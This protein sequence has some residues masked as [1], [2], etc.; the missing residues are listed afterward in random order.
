M[1][2]PVDDAGVEE[3]AEV[4]ATG[5]GGAAAGRLPAGNAGTVKVPLHNGHF[6]SCPANCSGTV[7]IF[8]HIGQSRFTR[9]L[10]FGNSKRWL[11]CFLICGILSANAAAVSSPSSSGRFPLAENSSRFFLANQPQP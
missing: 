6:I 4:T 3:A 7:N 10:L 8:W 9:Y 11:L 5:G 1:A 2:G